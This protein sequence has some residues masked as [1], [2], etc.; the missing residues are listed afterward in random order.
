MGSM[1]HG[2]GNRGMVVLRR[3][4]GRST[5]RME[6]FT[7]GVIAIAITLL[8][9]DIHV[10]ARDE[11]GSLMHKLGHLW[12]HYLAFATSYIVIGI[13]WINHHAIF[14]YIDHAD[15]YLVVINIVF[16]LTVSVLPFTTALVSEYLGHDGARTAIVAYSGW[17]LL[18]A[19]TFNLLWRWARHANLLIPDADP[20]AIALITKRFNYGPPSYLVVLAIS[21]VY[22]TGALVAIGVLALVYLLPNQPD[23]M[24]ETEKG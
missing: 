21:F 19:I 18:L 20:D 11:P 4:K 5:D 12:P 10:P 6:A 22:P 14:E 23:G 2:E 16:L 13:L 7:D 3:R 9:L 15:H 1:I 8:T 17:F 24:R